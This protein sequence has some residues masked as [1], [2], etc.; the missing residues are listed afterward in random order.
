MNSLVRRLKRVHIA[1]LLMTSLTAAGPTYTAT[2]FEASPAASIESGRWL[3]VLPSPGIWTEGVLDIARNRLVIMGGLNGEVMA[4]PLSGPPEWIVIPATG[5]PPDARD[6]RRAIYDA[7]RDRVVLFGGNGENDVWEL[8]F[9][10]EPQWNQLSPLGGPPRGRYG[11]SMIYD[12]VQD[13]IIVFAGYSDGDSD[14]NDVWALS[15]SE[16]TQWTELIPEGP[17]PEGRNYHAAIHDPVR[18]RMLMFGGDNRRLD[19]LFDDVWALTLSGSP[20]WS[21][22]S[23]AGTGPSPRHAHTAVYDPRRDRMLMFG[24]APSSPN[25]VWALSLSDTPAWS[26]LSPSGSGPRVRFLHLSFY[27]SVADQ[28]IVFGGNHELNDVWT[29]SLA[30]SS[31]WAPI[32]PFG[33]VPP[34]GRHG[35]TMVHDFKNDRAVVFGGTNASVLLNDCWELSLDRPVRWNSLSPLGAPPSPR[36]QHS[37][38]YDPIRQRVL[39]FGGLSSNLL[40]EL[41]ALSVS[42]TPEWRQI[43][44]AGTPPTARRGHSAIYDPLGDRMIVFGGSAMNDVWMLSLSGTPTWTPLQIQ[45]SMPASRF[46]HS[47]IYDPARQRMVVFGGNDGGGPR[48]DVWALSLADPPAWNYLVPDGAVPAAR[49]GHSAVYDAS[50]DRMV[51]FGGGDPFQRDVWALSLSGSPAWETVTPEGTPPAAREYHAAFYDS[52]RNRMWIFGGWDGNRRNDVWG[53][54]WSTRTSASSPSRTDTESIMARPN[55]FQAYVTFELT[56]A[57]ARSARATV[58]DLAGRLVRRLT[59]GT[60]SSGPLRWDGKNDRGEPV[61]SGLYFLRVKS[62]AGSLTKRVVLS[63]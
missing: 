50:R 63:R 4:L 3:P 38:I 55:P 19:V 45:G 14:L 56:F 60:W 52:G 27:D 9:V 11:H 30:G 58:H 35:H 15:L 37:A 16:P 32:V 39:V 40:N 20:T 46:D 59:E 2:H 6:G 28:M 62:T 8:S 23:P 42:A 24:G 13:R 22:I 21:Q 51:I 1:L 53:L 26:A 34:E 7:I 5:T 18:H 49:F 12:P 17:L 36:L 57:E 54:D 31:A 25:D 41:W 10:G 61:Q 43:S 29:L 33:A 48:N 47:A 44:P